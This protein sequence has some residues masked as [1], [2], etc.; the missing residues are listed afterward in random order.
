MKEI[1]LITGQSGD[2][3]KVVKEKLSNKYQ[4]RTLTT[5]KKKADNQSIFY[6]DIDKKYIK[7]KSLEKCNHIIHLSGYP[8]IKKMDK[9]KI[10]KE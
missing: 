7:K 1:I 5:N 8:I 6:W 2:L 9:K 10:K 4:I 3:A